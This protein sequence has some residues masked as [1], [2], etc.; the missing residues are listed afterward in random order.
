MLRLGLVSAGLACA[1]WPAGASSRQPTIY[2]SVRYIEE[3]DDTVGMELRIHPGGRAWI[4]FV[5]CEGQCFPQVRL[6]IATNRGGFT[7]TYRQSATDEAGRPVP[8]TIMHFSAVREGLNLRVRLK[9]AP[10][11]KLRPVR[12]PIAL[13]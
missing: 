4:D 2:S 1:L 12:E 6:P 5:L 8:D 13:D 3:A 11:E 7:F 10:S 9:G